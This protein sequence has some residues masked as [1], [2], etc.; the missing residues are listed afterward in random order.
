MA[1]P[2]TRTEVV[3]GAELET[4]REAFGTSTHAF[5][6]LKLPAAVTYPTFQRLWQGKPSDPGVVSAVRVGWESWGARMVQV[7]RE[8]QKPPVE[9]GYTPAG[10]PAIP[11]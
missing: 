5:R 2:R 8:A 1:R 6:C 10:S 7:V 11:A 3:D 4:W 9:S